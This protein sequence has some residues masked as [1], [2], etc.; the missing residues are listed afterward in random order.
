[1]ILPL[2]FSLL[3]SSGLPHSFRENE[4]YLP[5]DAAEIIRSPFFNGT[6]NFGSAT[7]EEALFLA[8]E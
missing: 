7:E 6:I 2:F 3:E 5:I 1:M 4:F 8:H